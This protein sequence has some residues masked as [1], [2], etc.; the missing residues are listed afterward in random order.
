M[1]YCLHDYLVLT[2]SSSHCS[3]GSTNFD[4]CIKPSPRDQEHRHQKQKQV[5]KAIR[6]H[7]A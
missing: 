5:H 6:V 1:V 7:R 4:G 2:K 3:N